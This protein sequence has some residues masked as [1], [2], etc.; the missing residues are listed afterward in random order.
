MSW[1]KKRKFKKLILKSLPVKLGK[2]S[3][4]NW[5]V[6]FIYE[7]DTDIYSKKKYTK[8]IIDISVHTKFSIFK[9]DIKS[10]LIIHSV[11]GVVFDLEE[12]IQKFLKEYKQGERSQKLKLSKKCKCGCEIVLEVDKTYKLPKFKKCFNCDEKVKISDEKEEEKESDAR[13]IES[14]LSENH[15][16]QEKI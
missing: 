16:E 6:D 3:N 13:A 10:G 8:K 9:Y 14:A 12:Y 2:Y 15:S 4:C 11:D 1:W 5:E 7:E